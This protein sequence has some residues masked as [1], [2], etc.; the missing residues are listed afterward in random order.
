MS[1]YL[2]PFL[3]VSNGKQPTPGA[4]LLLQIQRMERGTD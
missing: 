4:V 2:S 3:Q 1:I